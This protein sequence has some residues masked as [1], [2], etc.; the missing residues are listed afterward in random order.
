MFDGLYSARSRRAFGLVAFALVTALLV[1]VGAPLAAQ[2]DAFPVTI[3]HK[4][5]STTIT[6]APE[7]VVSLG[8]TDQ[9]PLL[10]LGVTPVAVRYFY[11]D[12]TDAIFPWADDEAG[13]A[14]PE[15]LNMTF[16][17]LNYEAILALDPDLII[18]V[19]SGITEEEYNL[20]SQIAPTVAQSA[21]YI[22]FGMPWDETTRLIGAA[23]GKS[24]EAE[25]LISSLE[26][27]FEQAREQNPEFEGKEVAV[28]YN[29][30]EGYG[31]YTDQDPR[32][33][34]FTDLGFVVPEELVDLAGDLFYANV[35]LETLDLLDRDLLVFVG[36]Q[37]AEGGQDAVESDPILSGLAAVKDGH[38]IYVQQDYDDAIQFSTVLSLEYALEGI[39]PEVQAA[40]GLEPVVDATAEATEAAG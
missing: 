5:G 17:A 13:S 28:A 25:A 15:V 29:M 20:L 38:V 23:V 40:L 36:L 39:V 6:E 37:F 19:Y 3:E 2:D 27:L 31:F 24:D 4:F 16:G 21:D 12:E 10:A 14:Q 18:A 7:R 32:G 30:G 11:G 1:G 8:F 26:G 34:F 35:S 33:R 22:D 9:D